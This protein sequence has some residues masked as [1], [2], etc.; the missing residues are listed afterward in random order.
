MFFTDKK[1]Q[2]R[3]GRPARYLGQ[4]AGP[5]DR[6]RQIFAVRSK[7]DPNSEYYSGRYD[8]GRA[9]RY[10]DQPGDI[11][12]VVE[13][14]STYRMVLC[15][16]AIPTTPYSLHV[17]MYNLNRSSVEYFAGYLEILFEDDTLVDVVF[18]KK[19]T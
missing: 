2:T 3:D 6:S 16:G 13:K 4:L 8:D 10:I 18:H 12:S 17:V 5:E 7:T 9:S 19:S 11:L 1:Y 15:S 14:R